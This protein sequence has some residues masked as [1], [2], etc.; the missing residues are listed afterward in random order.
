MADKS[1]VPPGLTFL[2][3]NIKTK[4]NILGTGKEKGAAWAKGLN[5]PGEA[6]T[7]FFAG[8]GYQFNHDLESLMN[9]LRKVDSSGVVSID[10]AMGAAGLTK[11]LGI[12]AAGVYSK[13]FGRGQNAA[14]PL[15]DAV[16]V[17]S[18]LGVKFGYLAEAEP[19]CSGSLY[20]SG[21]QKEFGTRAGIVYDRLKAKG[22]KHI[23]GIVPSCTYTL[24]NLVPQFVSEDKIEV[25]HFCEVV[26]DKI[27]PGQFKYPQKVKV[28]YHDPCQLVRYLNIVEEPRQILNSIENVELVEPKGTCREWATCCGGGGGF[29]VV[30]PELSLTLA[31]QRAKELADT[32]AEIV[33]THC[34]GCIMQLETGLKEIK[35]DIQVLDLSQILAKAMGA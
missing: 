18:A 33:V 13:L 22:V 31:K 7:I 10:L 2:A 26:A 5:L 23:I 15:K 20:F 14:E 25:R 29:E 24:R 11:K 17:L 4:D 19:C 3:D 34:P 6:E 27:K 35:A 9:L 21:L 28:T 32:G 8:C 12:N 16:K 30:F 1:L